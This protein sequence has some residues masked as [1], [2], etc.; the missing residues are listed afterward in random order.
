MKP[1]SI[2][3]AA[4]L[5]GGSV[6]SSAQIHLPRTIIFHPLPPPPPVLTV[7]FPPAPQWRPITIVRPPPPPPPRI[8]LP[9]VH[10]LELSCTVD[11]MTIDSDHN[12]LPDTCPE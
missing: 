5:A 10:H 3:L 6:A 2:L 4:S 11:R 7:T 8:E 9:E 12:G 1:L